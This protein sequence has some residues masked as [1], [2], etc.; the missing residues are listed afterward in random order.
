MWKILNIFKKLF[1]KKKEP[2]KVKKRSL[3]DYEFN[4]LKSEKLKKLNKIL[5]KIS[6]HGVKSLN[7]KEIDFLNKYK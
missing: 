6:N 4:E 5:D 1:F 2:E 7:K 3:T